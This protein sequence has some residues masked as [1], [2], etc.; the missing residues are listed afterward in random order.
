M[1]NVAPVTV[2]AAVTEPAP[3]A[4]SYNLM[5]LGVDIV[6]PVPALQPRQQAELQHQRRLQTPKKEQAREAR[7]PPAFQRPIAPEWRQIRALENQSR[8]LNPLNVGISHQ[9]PIAPPV[10]EKT[11]IVQQQR[12]VSPRSPSPPESDNDTESPVVPTKPAAFEPKRKAGVIRLSGPFES[13]QIND[14]TTQI[15]VGPI[16]DIVFHRSIG[17]AEICFLHIEHAEEFIKRD[18]AHRQEKGFSMLGP[19]YEVEK[20]EENDWTNEHADM[21]EFKERRRLTFAGA[22]L[23]TKVT[24]DKFMRDILAVADEEKVDFIWPFNSGNSKLYRPKHVPVMIP[25]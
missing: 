23:L 15:N 14:I 11:S 18:N 8:I 20:F 6:P 16:Y 7:N 13:A 9:Q 4:V 12:K 21:Y 17:F 2:P 5:D 10:Q 25:Y 19:G 1:H 22:G 3:A 24:E